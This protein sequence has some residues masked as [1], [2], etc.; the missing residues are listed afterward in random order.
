MPPVDIENRI[1]YLKVKRDQLYEI[2]DILAD[3]GLDEL[4]GYVEWEIQYCTMGIF[5]INEAKAKA[6]SQLSK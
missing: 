5:K 1:R 6:N 3:Y 2:Q 4:V